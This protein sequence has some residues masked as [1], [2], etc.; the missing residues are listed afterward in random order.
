MC[1]LDTVQCL[2]H[3]FDFIFIYSNEFMEACA[4]HVAIVHF[5]LV[6]CTLH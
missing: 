1:L 3:S 2:S 6:V 5:I 4:A